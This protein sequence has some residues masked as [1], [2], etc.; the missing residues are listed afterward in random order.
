[1]YGFAICMQFF[2]FTGGEGKSNFMGMLFIALDYLRQ[3]A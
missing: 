3:I 1:M 2:C